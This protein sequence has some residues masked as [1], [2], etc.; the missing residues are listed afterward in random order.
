MSFQLII[1]Y[2]KIKSIPTAH[3][4]NELIQFKGV[5]NSWLQELNINCLYLLDSCRTFI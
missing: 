1:K 4:I 3:E 5:L 2:S